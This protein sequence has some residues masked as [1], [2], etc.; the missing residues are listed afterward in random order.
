MTDGADPRWYSRWPGRPPERGDYESAE[1]LL[2]M[3]LAI[4]KASHGP[5]HP[6]LA[7]TLNNLAVVCERQEKLD[8]AEDGY[9]RAHAIALASLPPGHPV[10]ATSLRNLVDFCG[11]RGV[12]L[13]RP[14]PASGAE[15]VSPGSD[16]SASPAPITPE[17]PA[18][19]GVVPA[20]LT[21][22]VAAAMALVRSLSGCSPGRRAVTGIGRSRGSACRRPADVTSRHRRVHLLR[23][24][25]SDSS[26]FTTRRCGR[27][28]CLDRRP[29]RA[30]VHSF[31]EAGDPRLGVHARGLCNAGQGCTHGVARS[32]HLRCA[33]GD[34]VAGTKVA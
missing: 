16:A 11:A 5:T 34:C 18:A 13:W 15:T 8:D 19:R 29:P 2:R 12:P 7:N 28:A 23:V 1:R 17:V 3:A 25:N 6:D 30:G 14:P 31:G 21:R 26:I 20:R 10:I 9:R 33:A 32:C 27:L 24:G 22:R 4:Q